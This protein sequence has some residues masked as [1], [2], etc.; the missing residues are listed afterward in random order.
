MLEEVRWVPRAVYSKMPLD[1]FQCVSTNTRQ[2]PS[3]PRAKTTKMLYKNVV[4]DMKEL[5]QRVGEKNSRA[6]IVANDYMVAVTCILGDVIDP[7]PFLKNGLNEAQIQDIETIDEVIEKETARTNIWA[8]SKDPYV[9]EEVRL[10]VKTIGYI[11][12]CCVEGGNYV[13]KKPRIKASSF[14]KLIPEIAERNQAAN[15]ICIGK[16]LLILEGLRRM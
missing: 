13:T 15:L 3:R 16:Q 1:S 11:T 12:K 5:I 10:L 2:M 4:T 6:A 9:V 7:E 14:Q 8:P